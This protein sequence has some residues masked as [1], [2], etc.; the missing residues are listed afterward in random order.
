MIHR[1][2]FL[3]LVLQFIAVI[4]FAQTNSSGYGRKTLLFNEGWK[5]FKGDLE[6][7]NEFSFDDKGWR[8]VELPHD[9]SVEGPFDV[10]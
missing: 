2:Y 5:F 4:S 7:A 10:K 6:K 1:S 3:A 9:F 8:N